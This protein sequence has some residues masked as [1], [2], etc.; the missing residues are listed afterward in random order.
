MRDPLYGI[1]NRDQAINDDLDEYFGETAQEMCERLGRL[2]TESKP[3]FK[4]GAPRDSNGH[5]T[6]AEQ[7]D[8]TAAFTFLGDT[9]AAP[10]RGS[11]CPCRGDGWS[12]PGPG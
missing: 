2:A 8:L 1:W 5:H 3:K 9:P 7:D 12:A 11:G 10:R 6:A 4:N